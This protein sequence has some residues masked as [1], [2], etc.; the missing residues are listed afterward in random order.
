MDDLLTLTR[1]AMR[2]RRPE[3][4]PA[5]VIGVVVAAMF[6]V[7]ALAVRMPDTVDLRV[8]NRLPW[9][10]EVAVRPASQT[11]WTGVGAVARDGSNEF[12]AVPDQG[13]DWVIRYSYAGHT[14][15]VAVSRQELRSGGWEVQVPEAL[16]D[17]LRADGVAPTTGSADG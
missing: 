16:G 17:Q 2:A 12:L 15:D 1:P 13:S 11:S 14:E 7:A 4:V 5:I 6:L 9:R 8:S 10:A 3:L